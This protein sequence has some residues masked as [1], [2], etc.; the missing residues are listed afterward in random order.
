LDDAL[1]LAERLAEAADQGKVDLGDL[2]RRARRLLEKNSRPSE[3]EQL[4]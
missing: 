3:A 4:F 2:G 1:A